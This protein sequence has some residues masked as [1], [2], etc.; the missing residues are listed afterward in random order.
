MKTKFI[1]TLFILLL[2]VSS[3]SK[4]DNPIN[5]PGNGNDTENPENPKGEGNENSGDSIPEDDFTV[6]TSGLEINPDAQ[7]VLSDEWTQNI[8]VLDS[9]DF[10]LQMSETLIQKHN[11]KPGSILVS[12]QGDGFLRKIKSIGTASN[13]KVKIET[14]SC[15]LEEV[16]KEGSFKVKKSAGTSLRSSSA[17]INKD[18]VY[19]LSSTSNIIDLKGEYSIGNDY[20]F[21]ALFQGFKL[22]EFYFTYQIHDKLKFN[23]GI[24]LSGNIKKN[25]FIKHLPRITFVVAGVPVVVVPA[26]ALYFGGEVSGKFTP[27][28]INFELGEN[29]TATMA[30]DGQPHFSSSYNFNKNVQMPELTLN[31][32]TSAQ[33]KAYL[34]PQLQ[35]KFYGILAPYFDFKLGG[36]VDAAYTKNPAWTVSFIAELGGGVKAKILSKSLFDF[37]TTFYD[38]KIPLIYGENYLSASSGNGQQGVSGKKLPKPLVAQVTNTFGYPLSGYKVQFK[39][40]EGGGKLSQTEAT[41]NSDGEA[42]VELILNSN[43][44]IINHTVEASSI[45]KNDTPYKGEPLKNSPVEFFASVW[46]E[47]IYETIWT[48]ELKSTQGKSTTTVSCLLQENG[49]AQIGGRDGT[50][51]LN[52]NSLTINWIQSLIKPPGCTIQLKGTINGTSCSGT[53]T[54]WDYDEKGAR[55]VWDSGTFTGYLSSVIEN[56]F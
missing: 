16:I 2:L 34:E 51:S 43:K 46:N 19:T 26:I 9:T 10:N 18:D 7:T 27:L 1:S 44:D 56:D 48:F 38:V 54:H 25:L 33:I 23:A 21:Y 5:N 39:S 28:N 40:T 8:S 15:S 31:D 6:E 49:V 55:F 4:G 17:E 45:E 14:E 3:C 53:Y 24:K 32:K 41:T 29:F 35:F 12:D 22:Q 50:Y 20:E 36:Q 37:S 13:G 42:S 52:N 47:V 30:Y 11:L